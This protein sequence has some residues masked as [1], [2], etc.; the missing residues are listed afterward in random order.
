MSII[1]L[2]LFGL[3]TVAFI[4]KTI[5]YVVDVCL[6]AERSKKTLRLAN[7]VLKKYEVLCDKMMDSDFLND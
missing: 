4:V 2:V 7:K 6:G 5:F 1:A 3:I